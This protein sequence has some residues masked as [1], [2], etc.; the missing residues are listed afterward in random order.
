MRVITDL[1]KEDASV[2]AFL[3]GVSSVGLKVVSF[4]TLECQNFGFCGFSFDENTTK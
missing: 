2:L 1:V 4:P 3:E